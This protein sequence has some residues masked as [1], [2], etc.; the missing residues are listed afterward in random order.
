M[1]YVAAEAQRIVWGNKSA[2]LQ[3]SHTY[4]KGVIIINI[5]IFEGRSFECTI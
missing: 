3:V 2:L 5:I 4:M 1:I